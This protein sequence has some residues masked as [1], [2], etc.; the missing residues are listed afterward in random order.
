MV[1]SVFL[2]N[3][4]CLVN[5]FFH[6]CVCSCVVSLNLKMTHKWFHCH[7][8][9]S[10]KSK[11]QWWFKKQFETMTETQ[12]PVTSVPPFDPQIFLGWTHCGGRDWTHLSV[13]AS[14]IGLLSKLCSCSPENLL[15]CCQLYLSTASRNPPARSDVWT[16]PITRG[17]A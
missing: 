16:R 5:T 2:S 6:S 12:S 3:K 11:A 4:Q 17:S 15:I 13:T 14:S 7:W 9:I 1:F 10:I 8:T